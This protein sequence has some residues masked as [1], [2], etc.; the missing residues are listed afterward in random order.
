MVRQLNLP[1]PDVAGASEAVRQLGLETTQTVAV[2][3]C[4][5][6]DPPLWWGQ[7]LLVVVRRL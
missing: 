2:S 5:R 7:K 3:R 1:G 4:R 6:D